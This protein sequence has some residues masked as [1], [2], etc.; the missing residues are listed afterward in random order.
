M[1]TKYGS[2]GP[3]CILLNLIKNIEHLTAM[4]KLYT[5]RG[6]GGYPPGPVS[7]Q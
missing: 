7:F 3:I 4:I 1:I 6:G 5:E 2:I